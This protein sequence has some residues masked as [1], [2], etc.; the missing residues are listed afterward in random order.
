LAI[1]PDFRAMA[2][3]LPLA[4]EQDHFGA[5]S[6]RVKGKIFAQLSADGAAGLV[7]LSPRMQE[8]ALST[9]PD[10]C[11][12]EPNWGRHGWTRL[13]WMSL[14]SEVVRDWLAQSWRAV[15]PRSLHGLLVDPG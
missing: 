15:T 10:Q 2:L 12:S 13:T 3:A 6:F 9:Y 8:W 14:P 1:D 11:W 5:P 4:T 7:K